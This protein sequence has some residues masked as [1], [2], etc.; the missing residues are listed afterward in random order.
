MISRGGW[1]ITLAVSMGILAGCKDPPKDDAA[2]DA[3]VEAV[4]AAP[5]PAPS[6]SAGEVVR[7][8]YD[9]AK[10]QSLVNP[11]ALP[12]YQGP[13]GS[14]EGTITITGAPPPPTTGKRADF[15]RCPEASETYGSAFRVGPVVG[16][17]RALVDAVVAVT[18]YDGF[19]PAK[20]DHVTLSFEGCAYDRRTVLVTF[21]QRVDVFN[22]SKKQM[23]TPDIDGQP[24]LALRIAAPHSVSPVHVFPPA[25]GRFHL[26]DRGVLGYVDEDL[27]V[28]MH[29]L[30]AASDLKGAY[31]IDG[32]PVGKATVNV[33]HPAFAGDSAKEVTI[34]ANVVEKVDLALSYGVD[35]GG[36]KTD[37]GA[38]GKKDAGKV[39]PDPI[40]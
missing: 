12:V 24:V 39:T 5:S 2:R 4:D 25:P 6:A 16:Q 38:G 17:G 18:G 33:G 31:R 36:G 8:P 10:V 22:R 7:S 37:A 23:I 34:V 11:S 29:P 9:S 13:T 19:V 40:R 3:R 21:G 27:Y 28:L 1:R 26:I 14:V 20:S 30:H 15:A 35:A 32:I